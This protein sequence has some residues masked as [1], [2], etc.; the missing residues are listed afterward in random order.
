MEK[1]EPVWRTD[2][3]VVQRA[4][5]VVSSLLG[6]PNAGISLK[7]LRWRVRGVTVNIVRGGV[8][9]VTVYLTASRMRAADVVAVEG[10]GP[11]R[12]TPPPKNSNCSR[13]VRTG[14]TLTLTAAEDPDFTLVLKALEALLSG[15]ETMQ[16]VT[17][18]DHFEGED[19]D[20]E[21][22][23]LPEGE[24]RLATQPLDL[25]IE[26]L[27]NRISRGSIILQPEFQREY[28]WT[29]AKASLLIE[30]LLMRIPLPIVYLSE[31]QDGDWEVVDGQQRLTS[32]H[33]FVIGKF[34]DGA[35]FKLGR[36]AVR[37]D[38][39][40]MTFSDLPRADQNAILNYTLRS[41]VLQKESH[42]DLKFEVFERLNCGSVQLTDAE[43]RNCMYRGAYNNLLADLATNPFLLKVRRTMAPHKRM[44]DRQLILR[45][46]AMKRN[47]HLNY[48]GS[49]KAF[50]N[51]EIQ[52]FQ[53]ATAAQIAEM[54]RWFEDAIESAWIV[55][56][57]HAF[58]RWTPADGYG[59]EAGWDSKLNIA[60]WDT[61]LYSFAM[62]E[63]RQI[64]PA[65][66]AIREEFLDL[67]TSDQR[68]VDCIGRSTDRPDR[69]Q[70]RADA[71][72]RRLASVIQVPAN[73][74][75][76]FSRKLKQELYD[77]DAACAACGQH[78]P[79]VD[80][81]EVD[82]VDH[83][84]RGGATIPENARLLHRFCN[85]KR[86]GRSDDVA[87]GVPPIG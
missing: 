26:T 80:D 67:M 3:A 33:S 66:D 2:A 23:E 65:A 87:F 31:T 82:H 72:L 78:I 10:F 40:G 63:K 75:R 71:W 12:I 6:S 18:L 46:L 73:E 19:A 25:T 59:E 77:T 32:I 55:F 30:S 60:L 14:P 81:A 9:N 41:V 79:S 15:E 51:H 86:G 83:Y 27:S 52:H 54:R 57:D 16:N 7:M 70:Y 53:H 44:E 56:G 74:K 20:T 29:S 43:L 4:A 42:P 24:R 38:L 49:M 47:T 45:F 28:V 22:L 17:S 34:P 36:L 37:E 61:L 76:L 35:T 64:I 50:M 58:R 48:R 62:H 84:W 85:R 5:G 68:F 11:L 69:L 39:R 1:N 21:A 13:E 8:R